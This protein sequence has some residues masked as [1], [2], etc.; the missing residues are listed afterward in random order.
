MSVPERR[1]DPRFLYSPWRNG[2]TQLTLQ[3]HLIIKEGPRRIAIQLLPFDEYGEEERRSDQLVYVKR[4]SLERLGYARRWYCPVF[5]VKNQCPLGK[6]YATETA[7]RFALDLWA[8][9]AFGVDDVKVYSL[10]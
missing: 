2:P 3:R 1:A 8:R 5:G 6:L 7:A 10:F 4:D 9:F